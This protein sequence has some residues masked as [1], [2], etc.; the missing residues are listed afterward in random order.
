VADRLGLT[1]GAISR[2]IESAVAAGLMTVEVSPHS[3]RENT[4][5][6][7]A[8]GTDVVRRGDVT[9][10]RVRQPVLAA[11]DQDDLAA[12]IRLLVALD[13]QLDPSTLRAR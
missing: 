7:T 1:K 6:L 13:Q 5:A 4:V 11:V 2:Q 10:E 3:R 8:A 12:A 9:F